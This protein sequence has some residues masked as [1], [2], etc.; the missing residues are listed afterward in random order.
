MR[1]DLTS[2]H[3]GAGDFYGYCT[4]VLFQGQGLDIESVRSRLGELGG[5]I[6]VVG[7]ADMLKVHVHTRRPGAV[8]DLATDLGEIIKV[9]I[10]NMQ[11]QH[12]AFAALGGSGPAHAERPQAPTGGTAI[13]A[14]ALGEGFRS[15]FESFGATVVACSRTMNASVGEIA[16]AIES[17]SRE[18]VIV[19]PNDPNVVHAARQAAKMAGGRR[20]EVLPTTSMPQGI[21][22]ALALNPGATVAENLPRLESAA[23][24]CRTISM[25]R[26]VRDAEVGQLEVKRG[27]LLGFLDESPVATGSTYGDVL[28]SALDRAPDQSYELATVY[29]GAS[30][31]RDTAERLAEL[32]ANRVEAVEITDGGQ[33]NFDYVIALE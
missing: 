18:D 9:K 32:L 19:L 22:A 12:D 1:A 27:F 8:L 15:I 25:A 28:A 21:A 16:K 2:L 20:V 6:L 4:E 29:S 24:A 26:A 33:P 13:V 11:L 30:A 14:V 31:D 3:E 7:D 10:D 5:S 17:A 23:A